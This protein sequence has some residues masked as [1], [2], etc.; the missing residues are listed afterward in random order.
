MNHGLSPANSTEY[1][2]SHLQ[3]LSLNLHNFTLGN[4]G[5]WTL[6]LDTLI[7]SIS[8]GL[9]V[10]GIFSFVARRA[11][12]GVPRQ[13]QNMVE[14]AVLFVDQQVRDT[15]Q[16]KSL[17]LSSLA[18]TVFIWVFTMNLMDLLPVD[19]F[20]RI[21]SLFGVAD[22]RIVATDDLNVTFAMSIT[23]F[24]ISIVYAFYYKGAAGYGK[25]ILSHPFGI[26]AF[27]VNVAL[28]VIEE[29]ARP[30]SLSLRLFGNMYA[31]ELIFILI[32]IIPWWA[33]L[34][35]PI[36]ARIPLGLAT[37]FMHVFLGFVW[38]AFHLL[39]VLLQAFIFMMLTTVYVSLAAK[40]H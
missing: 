31:G 38:T 4:G 16:G 40:S 33:P 29:I 27:P 2:Q 3:H 1:I 13:W 17:F 15:F 24:I 36:E 12:S 10:L 5:F 37:L 14:M 11:T 23:V 32:A 25:E 7:I 26:R 6:N 21:L 8:L 18:L 35:L 20:S 9:I 28:R 19:L 22:V 34:S 39:I 30:I